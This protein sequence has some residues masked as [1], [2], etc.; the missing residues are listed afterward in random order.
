MTNVFIDHIHE[1]AEL[2]EAL[3]TF[4]IAAIQLL[5]NPVTMRHRPPGILVS[6][7][8]EA[9][10]P[11]KNCFVSIKQEL[12]SAKVMIPPLMK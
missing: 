10:P 4:F 7:A 5:L 2:A 1:E 11:G 8:S 3:K 12:P 9:I 6:S